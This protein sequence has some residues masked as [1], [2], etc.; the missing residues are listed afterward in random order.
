[1]PITKVSGEQIS[2]GKVENTTRKIHKIY[3]EKHFDP[4]W[5]LSIN[6][7]LV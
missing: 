2:S 6:Y 5:S 4:N 3:W 7:I 1:M